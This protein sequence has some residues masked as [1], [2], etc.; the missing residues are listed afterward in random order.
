[1]GLESL[2]ILR[3]FMLSLPDSAK[4][5]AEPKAYALGQNMPPGRGCIPS[6]SASWF[7]DRVLARV[8][9]R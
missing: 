3:T 6:V 7:S 8:A 2:Y 9:C 5:S 4:G 1:M